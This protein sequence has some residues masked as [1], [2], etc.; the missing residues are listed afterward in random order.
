MILLFMPKP[1]VDWLSTLRGVRHAVA[2]PLGV[3]TEEQKAEILNA[4]VIAY[5]VRRNSLRGTKLKSDSWKGVG[6]AEDNKI[7]KPLYKL[8]GLEILAG[9][10]VDSA[11]LPPGITAFQEALRKYWPGH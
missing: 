5:S 4:Q 11:S 8:K 1:P 3:V 6:V 2:G 9:Q 7:N 10:K